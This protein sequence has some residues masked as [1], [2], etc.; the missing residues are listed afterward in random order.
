M[1]INKGKGVKPSATTL[2]QVSKHNS[3][4]PACINGMLHVDLGVNWITVDPISRTLQGN[5]KG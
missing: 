4:M 1:L 2:Y 3:N 5:W